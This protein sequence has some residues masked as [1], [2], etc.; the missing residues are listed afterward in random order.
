MGNTAQTAVTGYHRQNSLCPVRYFSQFVKPKPK[1]E[2]PG[3]LESDEDTPPVC[4]WSCIVSTHGGE[5]RQ[6]DKLLHGSSGRALTSFIRAPHSDISMSQRFHFPTLLESQH[7]SFRKTAQC[8]QMRLLFFFPMLRMEPRVLYVP[9]KSPSTELHPQ[10][11][12]P[13]SAV[14]WK[15]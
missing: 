6:R 1:L 13:L 12:V 15:T 2:A 8:T 7:V 9:G 5:S 14:V 11:L 3:C 4:G 10:P